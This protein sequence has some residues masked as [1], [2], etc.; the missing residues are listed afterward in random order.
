MKQAESDVATYSCHPRTQ[1][2]K[3]GRLKV[4]SQLELPSQTLPQC[5]QADEILNE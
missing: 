4:Q 2:A 5:R 1:E 3:T